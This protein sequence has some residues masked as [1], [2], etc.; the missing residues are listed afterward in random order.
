VNVDQ[1]VD[2]LRNDPATRR[3]I[4]AWRTL[5]AREARPARP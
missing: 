4:T 1:F 2:Q 5:P 3:N